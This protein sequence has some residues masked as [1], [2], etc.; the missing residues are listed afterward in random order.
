MSPSDVTYDGI[1][2][3]DWLTAMRQ[4]LG[5][6]PAVYETSPDALPL[7][8]DLTSKTSTEPHASKTQVYNETAISTPSSDIINVSSSDIVS[9]T[10]DSLPDNMIHL[11]NSQFLVVRSFQG[12]TRVHVRKFVEDEI[13]HLYPTKNGISL[14]PRVWTATR[15]GLARRPIGPWAGAPFPKKKKKKKSSSKLSPFEIRYNGE[16]IPQTFSEMDDGDIFIQSIFCGRSG[17]KG[18]AGR[19]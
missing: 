18:E 10:M 1:P 19:K 4:S 17:E 15:P 5:E 16:G 13:K 11:G 2:A 6:V 14:T 12:Q 9:V 8:I 7:I 3:R